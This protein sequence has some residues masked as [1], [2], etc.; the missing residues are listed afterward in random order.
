MIKNLPIS[1][2]ARISFLYLLL[3]SAW[4]F[5]S[6]QFISL[7]S[8]DPFILTTLQTYKGWAFVT[9]T[10]VLLFFILNR[11][12]LLLKKETEEQK[13]AETALIESE[14][15]FRVTLENINLIG[16]GLDS[17]ANITFCNDYLLNLSG[18]KREEI[19]GKNWFDYFLP[20]QEKDQ[21][22]S[23]FKDAVKTKTLPLHYNNYLKTRSG[24]K[25]LVQ[26]DNTLLQNAEGDV[27]GTI[28]IGT[29]I[30]DRKKAESDRLELERRLLHA[31]KL[32]SLGVLAGGIAHDFN[33]LLGGIFGYIDLAR[34]KVSDEDPIARHLDKAINV[35]NRARDLTQQ[36]LTFAKGGKPI[37][38]TGSLAPLLNDCVLFALSGS[39]VSC[40]FDIDPNLCLCDFDENQIHQVIENII[41]NSIQSMPLG[42]TIQVTAKNT[43][44]PKDNS[45]HL[46]GGEYA[47]ISV[48]DSGIGIPKDL[49]SR[50]FEPF[51]TTKQKGTG[52]GLATSYS[53][54]QKHD[55]GIEVIS[56]PGLGSTFNI[57]LPMSKNKIEDVHKRDLKYH[58][59]RGKILI[60]DDEEFILEIFS[61]ML[62]RMGYTTAHAKNGAEAIQLFTRARDSRQP[63]DVLIFDLTIPGGMGGEKTIS[64]IRKI[65]PDVIAIASSGY[66]EDPIISSPKEYGFHASLRKPFRK[67]DLAEL[68]EN[69]FEG[70]RVLRS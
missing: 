31:Q 20:E 29:D 11:Y 45:K 18:W 23:I 70:K 64:E 57:Y 22:R 12:F 13:V 52:L 65:D 42:G 50:I 54:I 1:A 24:E 59:G 19:I 30:T 43:Y 66:S 25:R 8:F 53:I 35:F 67:S 3:A 46:Q 69:V 39:N 10:T 41:I 37:R 27:I 62:E 21:V 68:L 16:L 32:E 2:P 58:R 28:S 9:T 56:E 47:L 48:K 34:E 49:L 7:L 51:F 6:D 14:R 15:R 60:M 44:L 55:G 61:D 63:F 33:N 26:W 4:I 40:H 38:K 5:F 36:L 17:E